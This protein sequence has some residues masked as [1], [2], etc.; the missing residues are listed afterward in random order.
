MITETKLD[1]SFPASRFL[2]KGFGRPF[3]LDRSKNSGRILLYI[4]SHITSTQLNKY[5][6]KNQIKAFFVDI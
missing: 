5:I 4:K 2:M 1:S 3:R 6:I